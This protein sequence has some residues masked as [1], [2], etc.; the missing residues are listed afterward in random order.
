M[1]LGRSPAEIKIMDL[2]PSYSP[3]TC[4]KGNLAQRRGGAE[5]IENGVLCASASLRDRDDVWRR[6]H[7]NLAEKTRK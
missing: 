5:K 7:E 1:G 4:Q 6:P 3:R 2:N